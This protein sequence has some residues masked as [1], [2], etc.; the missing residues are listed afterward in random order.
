ME[1]Q[2]FAK[3]QDFADVTAWSLD[4]H[5][6]RRMALKEAQSVALEIDGAQQIWHRFGRMEHRPLVLIHGGS[7]SWTH[8][9]RNVLSLSKE[10]CVYALDMPG[11]GD[12][13]LPQ[14]A[15]DAD[16]ISLP[17]SMGLRQLFGQKAV[18]VM[19][20]SFGGL[21]AGFLASQHPDLVKSLIMVGIPGLGL[22]GPPMRLRGLLPGMGRQEILDVMHNNLLAM[23]LHDPESIDTAAL[24][25]QAHNVLRDR[26]RKRRLA[27]GDCLLQ[28][29]KKWTCPVHTIWGELDILYKETMPL[30]PQ[31]LSACRHVSHQVIKGAGHW[32]MYEKPQAFNNA[33]LEI[34][35]D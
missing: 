32:V 28:E 6:E 20:F 26:L 30:I 23:M 3:A 12:S 15:S 2:R 14:G 11:M 18:D 29:Q 4:D 19:G 35:S 33:V 27:R 13:D 8:W 1:I 10:R 31:A 22:F 21:T 9:I 34:L 7:G 25:I 17:V 16:D 24:Y 5:D